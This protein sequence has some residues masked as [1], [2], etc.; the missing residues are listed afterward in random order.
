MTNL[1]EIVFASSDKSESKRIAQRIRTGE[2]KKIAPKIYTS[3]LSD[4]TEK[5][6][7]RNWFFIL[8]HLYAGA[9]LSHRSAFEGQPADGHIFLTYS[10]ARNVQLP[11]LTV[12]LLK[13][14]NNTTGTVLFFGHLY[15]SSEPRAYLEN[16]EQIRNTA[17]FPKTLPR[18]VLESKLEAVIRTR[19]ENELNNIRDEARTLAPTLKQEKEFERLNKLISALLSTQSAKILNSE[20]AKAR[21]YGEPFDPERI[22]LFNRLYNYLAD[23][24]FKNYQEQNKT[25]KSYHCFAFFESYFSNFI[26]GT[27]FALNEAKEIILTD[28]PMPARDED[29]HD[30]L[31]TYRLVSNRNEMST[32][33]QSAEHLLELLRAR[34]KILLQARAS[35]KP[36][37]F[38]DIN[39]LAD[40]TEF[41]DWQLVS[42]TLKKGYQWY[43]LLQSPFVRACYM[44]FLISEVHP[45]IDGNGRVA[46]IMMNAELTAAGMSKIIIPTVY[47]TDYLGAIRKLTRKGEAETYVRMLGR[48]YE[49]SA[50]IHGEDIDEVASY[51]RKCNAFESGEDYI[52]KF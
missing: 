1:H 37:Q 41:V 12:H 35:K 24:E 31:G 23:K 18:E 45:F 44:M 20:V 42:G 49:F 25:D 34:H 2:L 29:S 11:G 46:R 22:T 5:I 7:L 27:E 21:A 30:I 51:L 6:I 13:G 15:R 10:S 52:L 39:N 19:G 32:L 14:T 9:I 47:R 16:M 36:G 8:S 28:T 48:A 26:E 17:D 50:T 40:D 3:N 38:K 43:S 4:A 33:P